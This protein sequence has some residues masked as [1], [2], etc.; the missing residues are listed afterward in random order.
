MGEIGEVLQ[1]FRPR[2]VEDPLQSVLVA[3]GFDRQPMALR[4]EQPQLDVDLIEEREADERA[5][6]H[7]LGDQRRVL[8]VRLERAVVLDL[9]GPLGDGREDVHN[10][11]AA[12]RKIVR[13]GEPVVPGELEPDE[14]PVARHVG[15]ERRQMR[16]GVVEP[17]ARDHD[18]VWLRP[19][20]VRPSRHQDVELL[21]RVDTHV[22]GETAG[23]EV[24]LVGC[25]R[26]APRPGV[27]T[28]RRA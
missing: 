3:R 21:R 15:E 24:L 25:H 16:V 18:L 22:D 17:H 8:R 4:R 1:V 10:R 12:A 14:H 28:A 23:V 6:A 2:D 26:A 13:E 11:V 7:E 9:L 20:T 19:P 27:S 5:V